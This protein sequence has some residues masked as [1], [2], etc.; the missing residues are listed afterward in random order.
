VSAPLP[1][2][3]AVDAGRRAFLACCASL[4]ASA[5]GCVH[6]GDRMRAAYVFAHDPTPGAYRPIVRGLIRSFL[7]F[8][9]PG[10][11]LD[12]EVVESRL[13]FLFHFEEDERYQQLQQMLSFFDDL[14]LFAYPQVLTDAERVAR[15]MEARGLDVVAELA[16]ARHADEQA[17][18]DFATRVTHNRFVDLPLDL[19][20]EYVRLW[21]QSAFVV[22]RRFHASA[23]ALIMISAYSLDEMWP[24]IGYAG[25]LVDRGGA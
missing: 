25:P 11:P 23:R 1:D 17:G 20:R 8:E 24:T 2:R 3:S 9:H 16:A 19:Q 7:A 6:L 5:T 10:F 13:L 14:D 21:S 15:D 18:R 4:A 22:K 12:P